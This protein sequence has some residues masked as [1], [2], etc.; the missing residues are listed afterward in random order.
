MSI[1]GPWGAAG[2]A[3]LSPAGRALQ[4]QVQDETD[5]VRRKRQL[6]AKAA[7]Y[8]PAGAA[9]GSSGVLGVIS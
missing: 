7:G 4:E 2:D 8:S 6:E 1:K 3:L 5:E 9:L